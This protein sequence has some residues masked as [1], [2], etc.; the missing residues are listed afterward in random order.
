[1]CSLQHLN[2]GNIERT[3]F[4]NKIS[5]ILVKRHELHLNTVSLPKY[6]TLIYRH[7]SQLE[8]DQPGDFFSM[9]NQ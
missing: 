7:I 2:L 8:Q 6:L 4:F 3:Y 5:T 1:M 9:K